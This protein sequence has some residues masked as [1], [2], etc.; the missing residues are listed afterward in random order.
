[1]DGAEGYDSERNVLRA[2]N[3]LCELVAQASIAADKAAAAKPK[4]KHPWRGA[5]AAP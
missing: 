3:R 1:M 2:V 5:G 4:P